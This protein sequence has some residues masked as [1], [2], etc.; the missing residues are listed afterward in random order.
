MLFKRI[1][2]EPLLHFVVV[3]ALLFFYLSNRDTTTKPEVFISQGKIKQLTAQFSKTRQ[4]VPSTEELQALIDNQVQE[5]LAFKHGTEMGLV[6][7][8]SIIK[9]R[10]QQKLEFMLNDSIASIEPNRE[11]L[12]A[13]LDTHKEKYTIA[14]VYSFKHIYINPE[15]HDDL[16]AFI[17]E[18]QTENLDSVYQDRG[19]DIMLESG[20]VDAST[21]AIARLFGRKFA[22]NLNS[23][24]L[25][26]WQGPVKSGYG[27]HLV[28]ID[29][30]IPEHVATLSEME[31]DIKRDYRVA[32]QKQAI[33]AF[34]EE[35]QKEYSVTVENEAH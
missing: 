3:G 25:D 34:Y 17:R 18:L 13:Y 16:N 33:D 10:V 22:Q 30:K 26:T 7:D 24:V 5:D 14:P 4:R 35:L 32:A 15:K 8:D 28:L 21:A 1:L 20:Y 31:L 6:E 19:D 11:E 12:Q 29:K 23:V 27:S 2:Q 9:R